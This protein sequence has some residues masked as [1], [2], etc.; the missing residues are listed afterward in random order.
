[1]S[2]SLLL[3]L[4]APCGTQN[5]VS[6]TLQSYV[7]GDAADALKGTPVTTTLVS[8]PAPSIDSRMQGAY[9]TDYKNYILPSSCSEQ[10]VTYKIHNRNGRYPSVGT[11]SEEIF[12]SYVREDISVLFSGLQSVC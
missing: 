10:T 1:M 11:T 2:K 8:A 12:N 4:S 7:N 9:T 3:V 5:G 6:Y